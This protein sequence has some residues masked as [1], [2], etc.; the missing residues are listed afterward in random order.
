MKCS[1][2]YIK[3]DK[4]HTSQFNHLARDNTIVDNT[5]I[6]IVDNNEFHNIFDDT[7]TNDTKKKNV[8]GE[9]IQDVELI[10]W[11]YRAHQSIQ[12]SYL[13]S[14]FPNLI[15]SVLFPTKIQLENIG[16]ETS[17]LLQLN[18]SNNVDN[19]FFSYAFNQI[20]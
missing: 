11:L 20:Y 10:N 9:T 7:K 14:K 2:W 3:Y 1:S 17:S 18:N 12:R 8:T 5:I 15:T 4:C 6:D 16:I 19:K 13:N